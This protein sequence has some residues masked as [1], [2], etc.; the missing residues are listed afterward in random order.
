MNKPMKLLNR[1]FVL[2]L[3]GQFV[4]AIGSQIS[5]IAL[6]FWIKHEMDSAAIIGLV[7]MLA[8]LPAVI[9]GPVGGTF[10]D[11]HS[12]RGIIIFSD[13]VSGLALLSL[14]ALMFIA[15]DQQGVI[16]LWLS[17]VFVITGLTAAFFTPAVT[18]AIPDLLPKDRVARGNSLTQLSLQVS[19]FLGQGLG[20][21]LFR[22]LGAPVVFMINGITFLF[23]AASEAFIRIPQEIPEKS[24]Q[25]QEQFREFKKDTLEGIRYM[26][27]RRGLRELVLVSAAM[28]FFSM[29]VIVLLPFYVEDFLKATPD[30]YGFLAAAYGLGSVIGYVIAGWVRV[31]GKSRCRWML[32]F[33]VLESAGHGLL[34]FVRDP[35]TALLLASL[36]G[37]AGGFV[38]VNILTLV[39]ITTPSEIRGRLFGVLGTISGGLAPLAMGLGGVAADL[40]NRNVSLIYLVCGAAMTAIALPLLWNGRVREFLAYEGTSEPSPAPEEPA[41][42][43]DLGT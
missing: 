23:S 28:G 21:T 13:I 10:A 12:R 19:V 34:G 2:L 24:D 3:Q 22:L 6:V 18:A 16:L 11:R 33:I 5:I 20:G 37:A 27:S 31:S 29:P 36:G 26:W 4:S 14:A 40:L 42:P 38:A 9:L 41:L 25:W 15:P 39:Q 32:G 7:Q 1:N 17:T 43:V 30:W 8:S 35:F